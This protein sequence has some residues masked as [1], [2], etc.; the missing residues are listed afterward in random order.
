VF[1]AQKLFEPRHG[2]AMIERRCG[3]DEIL[4]GRKPLQRQPRG[5]ASCMIWRTF[6][7]SSKLAAILAV[8][9]L[10]GEPILGGIWLGR[11]FRKK[12]PN[13]MAFPHP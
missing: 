4:Q 7:C 11:S 10:Q 9:L 3:A 2:P 8:Q 1:L 6:M 5:S 13:D 12:S